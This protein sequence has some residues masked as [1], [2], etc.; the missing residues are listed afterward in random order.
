MNEYKLDA[1]L[2]ALCREHPEYTSLYSTWSLNRNAC[3]DKLKS[4][5]VHYPHFSMHDASHAETVVS[6][7]EMLLGDRIQQ[8]SP[9]DTWLL[10]HAAYAH[11]L[12]M[13]IRWEQI[14]MVWE[15]PEFQEFLAALANSP[16][17]ELRDAAAFIQDP[18]NPGD[19][20]LWPLR[21]HR[22]V[23]LINAE[24]F[25]SR[26]A[27]MSKAYIHT[28]PADL[29]LDL[30]HSGLIQP[31]ILKL[32]GRICEI[33]TA[34]RSEL[35][36]LDYQTD[37]AGSDYAH[38]RF[39]AAF[40]R[41]GDLLDIDNG[42]FN[43]ACEAAFGGLPETSVPHREKHEA[44]THLLVTPSQI[45]FR[46]DCPDS[47]AYLETR[48]FVTWLEEE[49]DF[50]TKHWSQI[51]P[52][53]LGGY[54]PRFDRKELLINGTPDIEG[55][56]GLRFEISQERAFQ[57]I[58]GSNIYNDHMVFVREL[59][60]NAM[61]ASKLQL[62]RDLISGNYRAWVDKPD[63]SALQP[64]E[65]DR[66]IYE[67]YPIHI[68]LSTLEDGV[69]QVEI[70]DRGT[71]ISVDTFKQMCNVGTSNSGSRQIQEDIQSMPN[72]LRPTAGFGV[73]LQSIFLVSDQ[74]EID[75]GTG[76]DSFHAVVHANRLG[77]HL[78]L[79]RAEAPLPRGTTI[80]VRCR[81]PKVFH[82]KSGYMEQHYDPMADE[83]YSGEAQI[84][85]A[86]YSNCGES[87]FPLRVS[88]TENYLD[89]SDQMEP[90]PVCSDVD[91]KTWKFWKD[92]YYFSL[93]EDCSRIRIWDT[94]T[95]SYGEFHMTD[96]PMRFPI[97]TTYFKGVAL[98]SLIQ[99]QAILLDIYG[100]DTKSA[101]SLDR[102]R[103]S[104]A[105][106]KQVHKIN[107]ELFQIYKEC[108][109][110]HLCS[111]SPEQHIAMC[112]DG[113]AFSPYIF[114]CCCNQ[115]ERSQIPQSMIDLIPNKITV[116]SKNEHGA[117]ECRTELLRN[118]IPSLLDFYY[119]KDPNYPS[120]WSTNYLDICSKLTQAGLR[121]LK[122]I[123]DGAV[124]FSYNDFFLRD[125]QLLPDRQSILYAVAEEDTLPRISDDVRSV[126]V[127]GLS[128][129]IP[130]LSDNGLSPNKTPAKR[131]AIIA[132]KGYEA[133]AVKSLPSV[134]SHPRIC[135]CYYILAPFTREEAALRTGLS[136]ERFVQ[137]IMTSKTFPNVVNY[138]LEHS[139]QPESASKKEVSDAYKQLIEEYYDVMSK[140]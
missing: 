45:Q 60:Q 62:W 49:V 106:M 119:Y 56:A 97:S 41:L 28:T 99:S 121:N 118:A 4:V 24:Y 90:L 44:T 7:I 50:L 54:A 6:K 126:M 22:Y 98:E 94:K 69:T 87:M 140:E 36:D 18:D 112:Q 13:V 113:G 129:Y 86:I 82:L 67:C 75:T 8:L 96:D 55:V 32:L 111:T 21:T 132:F 66:K 63:L 31:R 122:I 108:I 46:S 123:H 48:N 2:N 89:N 95:F 12:G 116:L 16:D 91:I 59:I 102:S 104:T 23:N 79:Q 20:S 84:W 81:L 128:K 57:I 101:L 135:R 17:R 37:G 73:G 25:R 10:L 83:D 14:K 127:Q 47:R 19:A 29:R 124:P 5:V 137:R 26:H 39:V 85:D 80:R 105:G 107:N 120:S 115:K 65:L 109:F 51:A 64:Y 71:G 9:T 52:S 114:W 133:L 15:S 110:R 93:C 68:R 77:G 58:E 134:I 139:R 125:I 33:H 61:D 3:A 42:R 131:H 40:L 100:L 1:H 88:R 92:R 78:Q 138:V 30:G 53:Q 38:P 43:T 76:T 72:W 117:F 74:F 34:P 70:T 27:Q 130:W 103:L 11:D 136:K 35:L